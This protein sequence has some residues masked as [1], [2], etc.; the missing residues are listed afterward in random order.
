VE[1][2]DYRC[3]RRETPSKTPPA[4]LAKQCPPRT[5]PAA[6]APSTSAPTSSPGAAA[7]PT[8]ATQTVRVSYANG[9]VTGHTGRVYIALGSTVALVVTSAVA[10]EVHLHG[11][12]KKVD[13][14][15]NGTATLTF[16][17]T[18]PGVFEVELENELE[19]LSKTLV[20]L[21]VS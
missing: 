5:T 16:T 8:T 12:D 4:E 19:K 13:V 21:E 18:V 10:D 17:A 9:A 15:V 1:S 14:P 3:V 11:Y 6:P 7:T 20:M 2:S